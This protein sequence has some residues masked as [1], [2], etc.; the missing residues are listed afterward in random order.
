M[1]KR[2]IIAIAVAAAAYV[3]V[4]QA[5]ENATLT[6]RSG[7]KI[8]AQLVDLGGGGFTVR[9][10]GQERQIPTND[11]AVIDFAN[12]TMTNDDWAK[13]NSG[14]HVIWMR[15]GETINGNLY[16]IGGTS[17]LRLTL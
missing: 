10:N 8:S 3:G 6:L 17:P 2:T 12:S 9:V 1:L 15:S 14:Q 7:E 5:Q 4:V 16:D 13:V 11:V